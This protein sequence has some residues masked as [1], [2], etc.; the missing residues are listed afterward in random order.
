MKKIK[1]KYKII[2]FSLTLVLMINSG[3]SFFLQN[4]GPM[5]ITV[6]MSSFLIAWDAEDESLG[7]L[8]SSTSYYNL[9]YRELFSKD[10]ILLK[11]TMGNRT[12]VTVT[13]SE[14]DGNGNYEFGIEQVYRNGR[15]SEIHGSTDFS[16][17]PAG[18]WY[19]IVETP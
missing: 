3:C 16:A 9:Y 18:G 6:S 12:M 15:T 13:V 4:S 11:S 5:P 17:K 2:L 8:P 10:W 14:L 7:D 1:P 19:L